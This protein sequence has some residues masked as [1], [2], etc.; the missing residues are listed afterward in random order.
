MKTKRR[1]VMSSLPT[2]GARVGMGCSRWERTVRFRER[3]GEHTAQRAWGPARRRWTRRLTAP[4]GSCGMAAHCQGHQ[5][6]PSPRAGAAQLRAS[7]PSWLSPAS[8]RPLG[9]NTLIWHLGRCVRDRC[10]TP[11]TRGFLSRENVGFVQG[12]RCHKPPREQTQSW[13]T[14][15]AT[16]EEISDRCLNAS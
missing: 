5:E 8:P 13:P 16:A 14:S 12:P 9:R 10:V 15:G 4:G 3:L 6:G 2:R 1:P 7:R 11:T